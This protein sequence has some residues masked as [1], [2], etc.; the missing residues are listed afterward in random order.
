[1]PEFPGV[2]NERDKI[3]IGYLT[4]AFSGPP[5]TPTFSAGHKWEEL[6]RN[7][8]ILGGPQQGGQNQNWLPHHYVLGGPQMGGIAT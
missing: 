6:L 8:C 4:P 7:S 3:R 5:K 2:P 1:M